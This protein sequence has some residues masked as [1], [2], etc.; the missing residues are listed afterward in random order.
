MYSIISF[1]LDIQV[2]SS[3]VLFATINNVLI[4]I[5]CIY[6]GTDI[7]TPMVFS[8]VTGFWT[9]GIYILNLNRFLQKIFQT[10]YSTILYLRQ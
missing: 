3:S 2:I 9:K 5:L 8:L 1:L 6:L 7:F 4:N 10:D